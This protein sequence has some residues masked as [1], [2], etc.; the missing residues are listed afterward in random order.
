MGKDT[1]V[2]L[3]T[4]FCEVNMLP[5]SS[6]CFDK[7]SRKCAAGGSVVVVVS[8]LISLMEDQVASLK[9]TGVNAAIVTSGGGVS[10][11]FCAID[12]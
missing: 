7:M 4:G 9:E 6:V 10:N 12:D 3:P 2:W 5:D 11:E 1:F 8:A